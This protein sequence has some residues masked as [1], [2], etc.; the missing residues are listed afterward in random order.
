MA[1]E[2][3]GEI[4]KFFAKPSV[5]AIKIT[6]GELKVGDTIKIVGHT[7][8]FES[9]IESMEVNNKGRKAA[10]GDFIGGKWRTGH[11][12]AM[13]SSRS[14]RTRK[15]V[16]GHASCGLPHL[17][18]SMG[19]DLAELRRADRHSRVRSHL[20]TSHPAAGRFA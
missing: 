20:L 17:S 4:V 12:P 11:G 15:A 1:E 2:K 3:I 14:S 7:T 13:R 10:A 18:A 16:N 19:E 8:S 5:A 9:V 6:A